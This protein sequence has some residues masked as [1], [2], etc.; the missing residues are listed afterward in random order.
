MIPTAST[1]DYKRVYALPSGVPV[2]PARTS[3]SQVLS[4]IRSDSARIPNTLPP[5]DLKEC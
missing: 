4:Y 2:P 5:Q 1:T 3:H